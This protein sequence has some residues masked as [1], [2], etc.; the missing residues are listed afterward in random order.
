MLNRRAAIAGGLALGGVGAAG[1]ALWTSGLGTAG[2]NAAK[3]L[4]VPGGLSQAPATP[5]LR[6]GPENNAYMF[7][8]ATAGSQSLGTTFGGLGPQLY[9][10]VQFP[11]GYADVPAAGDHWLVL[12][13]R[14][15]AMGSSAQRQET[16]LAV[17]GGGVAK[18]PAGFGG[19]YFDSPVHVTGNGATGQ[20]ILATA[21]MIQC[22]R[23]SGAFSLWPQSRAGAPTGVRLAPDTDYALF[24][25]IQ[26]V[27]GTDYGQMILVRLADLSCQ[28]A[29]SPQ[30]LST[31]R[32]TGKP[33]FDQIG[34]VGTAGPGQDAMGFGG[35]V[36]DFAVYS[37]PFPSLDQ[38][39]SLASG[40]VAIGDMTALLG[41]GQLAYWNPLDATTLNNGALPA[42]VGPS[43]TVVGSNLLPCA[44]IRGAA[45][46]TLSRLG[47]H[48]VFP[49]AC[50]ASDGAVWFEGTAPPDNVVACQLIYADGS[51]SPVVEAQSS[52]TGA[53]VGSIRSPGGRPFFRQVTLEADGSRWLDGDI[54]DVGIVIPILG[55]S[56]CEH[57]NH[58][59]GGVSPSVSDA[60]LNNSGH[61]LPMPGS[62]TG[63]WASWLDIVDLTN[64]GVDNFHIRGVPG[65]PQIMAGNGLPGDGVVQACVQAI[66]LLK[67]S[68]MLVMLTRSGTPIDAM[69]W[70][71][72]TFTLSPAL[73][74]T[75]AAADPLKGVLAIN[76]TAVRAKYGFQGLAI[77]SLL[78]GVRPGSVTL[79]FPNGGA[80]VTVSD[81]FP[82]YSDSNFCIG[83]LAGDNGASGTINYMT[84][85]ISLTFDSPPSTAGFSATWTFKQETLC[86][87][88]RPKSANINGWGVREAADSIGAIGLRHGWSF[89]WTWWVTSNM[90]DSNTVAGMTANLSA[91]LTLLQQMMTGGPWYP[92]YLGRGLAIDAA[93]AAPPMII[94]PKGRETGAGELQTL[95]RVDIV[96]QAQAALWPTGG[97]PLAFALASAWYYDHSVDATFSPHEDH[98]D[99]GAR[100]IGRRM[101]RDW[102]AAFAQNRALNRGP[103]WDVPT[104][105]GNVCTVPVSYIGAGLTL[106]TA[107][108]SAALDEWYMGTATKL[109]AIV[110]NAV[111]AT[112][113]IRAD[114]LAVIITRLDG[115]WAGT[116]VVRY[117]VGAPGSVASGAAPPASL[118]YDNRGGF[119]GFEPGLPASPKFS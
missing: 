105:S 1:V 75:G 64:G 32:L 55:Q 35:T 99:Q 78:N 3:V 43:A 65:R 66:A 29:Q 76:P 112:A 108:N 110:D 8:G 94:A 15:A 13:F 101:A 23:K 46:V 103:E 109:G 24:L 119:G 77:K 36:G 90:S 86:G 16:L 5:G 118:L 98:A 47:A 63:P 62:Y 72:Q 52:S 100:R 49:M 9:R 6:L 26:G 51:Q 53:F 30:P 21:G 60:A 114:G 96:R 58:W 79:T 18:G 38:A 113:A 50:G 33:L 44:P 73:G 67:C 54:M 57:L 39:R 111:Y 17:R 83:A 115:D 56:E 61:S 37:A 19:V 42:Q 102:Q 25:G 74:G 82:G 91:K 89:A 27:S 117:V 7:S 71:G 81:Q 4:A 92:G 2:D 10:A 95:A 87:V 41:V 45:T 11:A 69:I 84:G 48:Y 97:S 20:D 34:A 106:A 107:G 88:Y 31:K 80:P 116:E 40:A 22:Q 70:D 93:C 68:V 104:F 59:R 12:F 14:T 28:T 85:A